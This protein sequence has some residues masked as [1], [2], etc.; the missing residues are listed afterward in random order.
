[1]MYHFFYISIL[2]SMFRKGFSRKWRFSLSILLSLSSRTASACEVVYDNSHEVPHIV[3]YNRTTG[4]HFDFYSI[5]FF[6]TF[7]ICFGLIAKVSTMIHCGDVKQ[8]PGPVLK[9]AECLKTVRASFLDNV[10]LFLLN[11]R[12]IVG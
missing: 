6:R 4:M 2:L 10:K 9:Y 7:N 1:M 5:S 12:S 11:F 8:N 3:L